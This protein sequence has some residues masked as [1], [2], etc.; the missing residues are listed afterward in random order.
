MSNPLDVF[1]RDSPANTHIAD[2]VVL[3]LALLAILFLISMVLAL[4]FAPTTGRLISIQI[5][6]PSRIVVGTCFGIWSIIATCITNQHLYSVGGWIN[7]ITR[8][9]VCWELWAQYVFGLFPWIL[10]FFLRIHFAEWVYTED[11][12]TIAKMEHLSFKHW[13]IVLV[14]FTLMCAMGLSLT[15]TVEWD[16]VWRDQDIDSC[17]LHWISKLTLTVWFVG[18][19]LALSVLVHRARRSL[20][21]LIREYRSL[22]V[23]LA[24][25][26]LALVINAAIATTGALDTVPGRCLFT[27]I[28]IFLHVLTFL[29]IMHRSLWKILCCYT[30]EHVQ[31]TTSGTSESN[32]RANTLWLREQMVMYGEVQGAFAEAEDVRK[33]LT[34]YRQRE[35]NRP[36]VWPT[37][38]ETGPL[39]TSQQQ[40]AYARG[41]ENRNSL[42]LRQQ[43]RQQWLRNLPRPQSMSN[44]MPSHIQE[45]GVQEMPENYML[46]LLSTEQR[47]SHFLNDC[48]ERKPYYMVVKEQWEE[49]D[50]DDYGVF[51]ET[52]TLKTDFAMKT[53]VA[54]KKSGHTRMLIR[55]TTLVSCSIA[56]QV[57]KKEVDEALSL[58]DAEPVNKEQAQQ[59]HSR[60]CTLVGKYF[61]GTED[62]HVPVYKNLLRAL[63]NTTNSVTS[64][65]KQEEA[66]SRL[67]HEELNASKLKE[68]SNVYGRK[69]TEKERE[70]LIEQ[71]KRQA[72]HDIM[73]EEDD[74]E[75]VVYHSS[76][77]SFMVQLR[78]VSRVLEL[79]L[80]QVAFML[81]TRY[82]QSF[83]V[84]ECVKNRL[85]SDTAVQRVMNTDRLG[86]N[87]KN[88]KGTLRGKT[89]AQAIYQSVMEKATRDDSSSDEDEEEEMVLIKDN[90]TNNNDEEHRFRRFRSQSVSL[91]RPPTM[92]KHRSPSGDW[93]G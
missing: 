92:T 34:E 85:V 17:Q 82:A 87:N 62:L 23:L 29:V 93:S 44:L 54:S 1:G 36:Q 9:C 47:W 45:G 77:T 24:L 65:G 8:C 4:L 78:Q 22:Q 32:E 88:I 35:E 37:G 31:T 60:Y 71:G 55:P 64:V 56:M 27:S 28:V 57:L 83:F 5:K 86:H 33:F 26:W 61:C 46:E 25:G 59:W 14:S 41:E 38:T 20:S 48:R 80:Q 30:R 11:S 70:L 51:D 21:G 91:S 89:V 76:F 74:G 84:E 90:S 15:F 53:A 66:N 40:S 2:L 10:I 81:L 12:P 75:N 72:T 18:W 79:A 73:S 52:S 49:M 7:E 16:N 13:L 50:E 58:N 63:M 6:Y 68:L 19:M 42:V 67:R 69:R 3:G 43:R 39:A